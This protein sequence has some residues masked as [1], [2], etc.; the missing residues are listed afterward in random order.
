LGVDADIVSLDFRA[1][2]QRSLSDVDPSAFHIPPRF[3]DRVALHITKHSL[4][5]S[6][7][8]RPP[9]I[10]AVWGGKGC[11]KSFQLELCCKKLGITPVIL[12]AGELED[13]TAGEPGRRLRERYAAAAAAAAV[14]GGAACLI[15]N[16]LDA[17]IGLWKHTGRTVNAQ[18]VAATLM[19]LCDEPARRD[20]VLAGKREGALPRVPI[21]VT[22]NDLSRV[23]APLLR[24]GRMDKFHWVPSRAD[25]VAMLRRMFEAGAL[26][27]AS[28]PGLSEEEAGA[29]VDAFSAQPPDFFGALASRAWDGAVRD[30]VRAQGGAAGAGAAIDAALALAVSRG[31][32]PGEPPLAPPPA[33]EMTLAALIAAGRALEN[34]QQSVIDLNLARQYMRWSD[35]PEEEAAKVAARRSKRAEDAA[36]KGDDAGARDA[37]AAAAAA[38][39]AAARAEV[40]AEKALRFARVAATQALAD[41]ARAASLAAED[42][43]EAAA[44]AAAAPVAAARWRLVSPD[45]AKSLLDAST[46]RLI[47][48]RSARDF[49]RT[50]VRGALSAPAY[51]LAGASLAPTLTPV[52]H[53]ATALQKVLS[54]ARP[55]LKADTALVMIGPPPGA[56]GAAEAAAA[57]AAL[58]D[59]NDAIGAAVAASD[60]GA[61]ARQFVELS[62][63]FP[64]WAAEFTP[65]GVRRQRGSYSDGLGLS[66]W[67]ASN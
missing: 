30:W 42:A 5:P 60:V 14:S 9:L 20:G 56:P 59:A 31:A 3:L 53:Y 17:G 23:Y 18:N 44:A 15:V 1:A 47:D 12:S 37:D 65:T 4:G 27:E 22:A 25:R 51:T 40:E 61:S 52:P 34:E 66:F 63:G 35:T 16:D 64:A 8:G 39:L 26:A 32:P 11:G 49:D 41:A 54:S 67:T 19:A 46:A 24:D 13:P 36:E 43:A 7:P 10:L 2:P 21:I 57:L 62:G 58:A 48:M 33:P 28:A 38:A 6:F 29:L 45:E 55:P 50:S